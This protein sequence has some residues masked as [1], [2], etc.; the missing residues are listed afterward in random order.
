MRKLIGFY[1]RLRYSQL[2]AAAAEYALL[3]TL[4]AIA[5]I[6]GAT[7]LGLGINQALTEVSA[8]FPAPPSP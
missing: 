7:A 6:I 8:K 5:I 3:V 1:C 2:G 4:I